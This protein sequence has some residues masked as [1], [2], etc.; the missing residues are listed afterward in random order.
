MLLN[1]EQCYELLGLQKGASI[2]EIKN[3]YRRMVLEYHPDKNM[4]TKNDVKFR[5]VTEAYQTIRT[6]NV[7]TDNVSTYQKRKNEYGSYHELLTPTFYLNLLYDIINY[8][9]K[10]L[11][12]RIVHR[13]FLKYAPMTLTCSKLAQKYGTVRMYRFIT[14]SY[15]KTKSLA[16]HIL[17]HG[18]IADM[19]KYL[20]ACI[21]RI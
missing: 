20:V 14:I 5:L 2:P 18:M 3:A 7:Y 1:I 8:A 16:L 4:S 12:A 13:Y 9:K 10:I 21:H 15:V 11:R 17:H 19:Q 6:K